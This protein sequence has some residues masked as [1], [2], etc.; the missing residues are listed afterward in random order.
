M[1]E[2]VITSTNGIAYSKII[3]LLIFQIW[4]YLVNSSTN[5]KIKWKDLTKIKNPI[6]E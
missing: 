5:K 2:L 1:L 6:L 4:K 3:T